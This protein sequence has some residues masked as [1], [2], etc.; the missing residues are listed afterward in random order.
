MVG[1]L[2]VALL[3]ICHVPPPPELG[4]E[5][6]ILE[7]L[8]TTKPDVLFSADSAFEPLVFISPHGLTCRWHVE[9]CA[10][11]FSPRGIAVRR[12]K[13]AEKSC[14]GRLM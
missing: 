9:L 12:P 4:V 1:L 5:D 14:E 13:M 10:L 7:K 11:R 3:V 8:E 2:V 6:V